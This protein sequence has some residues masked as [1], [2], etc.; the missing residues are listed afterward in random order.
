MCIAIP[1]EIIELTITTAKVSIMGVETKV[2][3]QL[4]DDPKIGDFVLIHAG[5][6]IEKVDKNYSD[7]YFDMIKPLCDFSEL[8]EAKEDKHE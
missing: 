6:A 3:I 8:Y 2:N 5:C 1:G 4:I 7:S